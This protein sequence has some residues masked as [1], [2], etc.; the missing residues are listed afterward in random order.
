MRLV[1]AGRTKPEKIPHKRITGPT[2]ELGFVTA[3]LS[4]YLCKILSK[5]ILDDLGLHR[6]W[7]DLDNAYLR[8]VSQLSPQRI[9]ESLEDKNTVKSPFPIFLQVLADDNF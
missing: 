3:E 2:A 6:P 8:V 1:F 7:A 9:K 5:D 4:P